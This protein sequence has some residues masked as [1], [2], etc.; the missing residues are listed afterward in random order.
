[1]DIKFA[2][3]LDENA[4]VK[5]NMFLL[6]IDHAEVYNPNTLA[7]EELKQGFFITPESLMHRVNQ[8]EL[9]VK[10]ADEKEVKTEVNLNGE[11]V[12]RSEK[13]VPE[14]QKILQQKEEKENSSYG[15]LY[16]GV[17]NSLTTLGTMV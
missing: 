15:K 3:S 9:E 10:K 14:V 12:F 16:R 17:L 11:C 7:P 5:V 6:D 2:I 4:E 8:S 1:M 13:S